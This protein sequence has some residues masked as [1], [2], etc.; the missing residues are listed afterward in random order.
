MSRLVVGPFNR[1]EGDLEVKLDID[2]GRVQEAFVVSPLYRGFEPMLK[3]KRPLDLLVY[4]PRI[5]GICSVSQSMAAATALAQ[6]QSLVPAPN[7]QIIA[8]LVHGVENVMDHLTHFYMFFMPDF[9]REIYATEPWHKAIHSRFAAVKGLAA[10]QVLPARAELFHIVGLLAGKWPHTLSLQPGGFTKIVEPHEK[11]RLKTI[12]AKFRKFA[13]QTVFGDDLE[14]I[15]SLQSRA[16]LDAWLG[17]KGPNNSDLCR[18]LYLAKVLDLKSLGASCNRYMSFGAYQQNGNHLF[19]RGVVAGNGIFELD[20]QK[21][22]EDVSHAWMEADQQPRHPYE[23]VTRPDGD[24]SNGYSWCK[25]PRLDGQICE[26]GALA[27]QVVDGHPLIRDMVAREGGNVESRIVAR[28]LEIALVTRAMQQWVDQ[29]K[30]EEPFLV[31]GEMPDAAMGAGLVEAARGS[32]GHWLKISD[33]VIENVQIIAPTT[34]NFS[35][36][37]ANGNEGPLEFALRGTPVRTG[38]TDP[39]AVQHVVRSFDP[40]MVCTVH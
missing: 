11:F 30:L 40:C 34:W 19:K 13:E 9:T 23:G 7:G 36:R 3:N 39:V 35:P 17:K 1:V 25:A 8:N 6:A 12:L 32:L 33:G 15:C 5:C 29:L 28:L 2:D 27:R 18:F 16:E 14:H 37:D 21:I 38:E 10:Q 31:H 24:M 20:E 26:V 22:S 4:A